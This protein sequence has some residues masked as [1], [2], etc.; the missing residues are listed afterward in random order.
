[1]LNQRKS[2][3]VFTIARAIMC[4]GLLSAFVFL[5]PCEGRAQG[6]IY[7]LTI[8]GPIP[9]N[10]VA[11][12]VA[13]VNGDNKPDLVI[14]TSHG[15]SLAVSSVLDFAEN[16]TPSAATSLTALCTPAGSPIV[17][18]LNK[19]GKSDVVFNCGQY[20]AVLMGNGDGTFQTAQYYAV[21]PNS[22][23][24]VDLK[25][26]GYPAIVVSNCA[27]NP[28]LAVLMNNGSVVAGAN[29]FTVASNPACSGSGPGGNWVE[30]AGDF[31]GDGK[32]DV[33]M[34]SFTPPS[35][36]S[37]VLFPG[38][39]DGAFGT[40]LTTSLQS[41]AV[42]FTAGDFN[43]DG[44]TDLAYSS[45]HGLQIL[46]GSS[47]GTF[48]TGALLAGSGTSLLAAQLTSSGAVDIIVDGQNTVVF[49][50]DGKGNF[51]Q[52]GSYAP[53]GIPYLMKPLGA[54]NE[55]LYLVNLSADDAVYILTGNGDATFQ[56][57]PS[58][59]IFN[60]NGTSPV[61][62]ADFNGDGLND[63]ATVVVQ[64]TESVVST[65]LARGDGTFGLVDQTLPT[66]T[67]SVVAGDFNRDGKADLIAVDPGAGI[68]HG[69]TTLQYSQV[70]FYA[71]NGNATFQ[72]GVSTSF[73]ILGASSGVAGDFNG[74]GKLDL[75]LPYDN[76]FGQ[77]GDAPAGDGLVFLPGKGDGTFGAP[78]PFDQNP[79][80]VGEFNGSLLVA[81]LR[82]NG[83]LDVIELGQ[84]EVFLGNGDGT[85]QQIPLTPA[86]SGPV[87][88][89]ADVNGDGIP[90]LVTGGVL[91]TTTINPEVY[92]VNPGVYLGNGD[93]TFQ[94][95]PAYSPAL[96]AGATLIAAAV[97]DVSGDGHPDLVL[98]YSFGSVFISTD[99][100]AGYGDASY[101]AVFLGDGAGNFTADPNTYFA[102]PAGSMPFGSAS[103]QLLLGRFNNSAPKTP[104]RTLD[105][106]W[107]D[108]ATATVLLNQK[109]AAPGP[110][111]P[112]TTMVSLGASATSLNVNSN[113]TLTALVTGLAPSGSVTFTAANT[114]LGTATL[115]NGVASLT[116]SFAATGGYTVTASYGGDTANMSAVSNAV[117][118]TVMPPPSFSISANPPSATL[119]AGQSATITITATP[120]GG[121]TGTLNFSCGTLPTGVT[122]N[123]NPTMLN[124]AGSPAS[125]T[126]TIST[127]AATAANGSGPLPQ[128]RNPWVP[129]GTLALAGIL[130]LALSGRTRKTAR[131]LRGM[132]WLLLLAAAMAG[133]S[134]CGSGGS[135]SKP[136]NPGTPSGSYMVSVVVGANLGSS[137]GINLSLTVQ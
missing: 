118:I 134:G 18:D 122:C 103:P 83:K 53:F 3:V 44:K 61:L 13:D 33:V 48:T 90:D 129:A 11:A 70:T 30:A 109:N 84:S 131:T 100:G 27:T 4:L 99:N 42:A 68:G 98:T 104:D 108:G 2:C 72:N 38:N 126:L 101:V 26:N 125:T 94:A 14:V 123:F 120:V 47:N 88:A 7:P 6:N 51:T 20:V 12:A 78:V 49:H 35:G 10:A 62:F 17:A 45:A 91:S 115:A 111:S 56:A 67:G 127:T 1:M 75:V 40:P 39:G 5:L 132:C 119:K 79:N 85:F 50:G 106:M 81:D 16:S 66:A 93:G 128:R 21:N 112:Y 55:N 25:G 110:P 73:P 80:P 96:P 107:V 28:Q 137:P 133:A 54:T 15:G 32:Q 130:G 64:G 86:N 37:L 59:T 57:I 121:Y 136:S 58:T 105:A 114:T 116:T 135:Y 31:N 36:N 41:S 24:I 8:S 43:G 102:G 71:G 22:I 97:A 117:N 63:F 9:A 19:D 77:Q 29:Q 124:V 76:I 87:L 113:V 82:N 23:L 52:A 74:D 92:L 89:I 95:A 69:N 60:T 65:A 46:F 34:Y